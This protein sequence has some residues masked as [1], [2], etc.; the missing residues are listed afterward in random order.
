[1]AKTPMQDMFDVV[2]VDDQ[3]QSSQ[4]FRE[5]QRLREHV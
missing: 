1:M 3:P 5:I 2:F 4:F